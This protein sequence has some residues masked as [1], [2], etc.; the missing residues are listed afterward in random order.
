MGPWAYR[1]F[2]REAMRESLRVMKILKE[3]WPQK[4]AKDAKKENLYFPG[5]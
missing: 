2:G 4:G 1:K 3:G 5:F